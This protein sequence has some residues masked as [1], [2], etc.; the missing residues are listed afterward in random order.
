MPST[1]ETLSTARCL[2][3]LLRSQLH[4]DQDKLQLRAETFD[5]HEPRFSGRMTE[6][7]LAMGEGIFERREF[8]GQLGSEYND[9]TTPEGWKQA[10]QKVIST[11]V[12]HHSMYLFD[13]NKNPRWNRGKARHVMVKAEEFIQ[14]SIPSLC[15]DFYNDDLHTLRSYY[16]NLG[17]AALIIANDT[18]QAGYQAKA[19]RFVEW[20]GSDTQRLELARRCKRIDPDDLNDMAELMDQLNPVFDDGAL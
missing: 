7:Y 8:R 12:R 16:Q 4:P 18:L 6:L 2:A 13:E 15:P 9:P 19:A 1:V 17:F 11:L 10:S 3:Y 20:A 14:E 5:A